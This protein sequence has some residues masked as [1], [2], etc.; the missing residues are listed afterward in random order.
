MGFRKGEI[1]YWRDSERRNSGLE[2]YRKAVFINSGIWDLM[3]TVHVRRDTG[4]EGP[5]QELWF[6]KEGKKERRDEGK[7]G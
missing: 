5:G 3:D 1:R 4:K 7:E 6:K 2:G